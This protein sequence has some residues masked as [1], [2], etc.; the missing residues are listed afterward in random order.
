[1]IDLYTW[2]T[3]NGFKVSIMLEEIALPYAVIPV[4]IRNGDQFDPRYLRL[5]PNNKIPTI[6]DR[7]GPGGVPY[8]VFESGA[9]LIYLAEKT[10][11]LMPADPAGRHRVLQ[12]LMFQVGGIGPMLGQAHHFRRYAPEPIAYAIERYTREAERLYRVMDRRLGEAEYLAGAYSIADI[13]CF[14]WIR[15]HRWQGQ[16]LDAFPN[17]KRW[18]DAV[19]ARPAVGRGLRVPA[20]AGAIAATMDD[21]TRSI[22]FGDVQHAKR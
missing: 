1:M 7:D 11:C 18:F 8:T 5:N 19:D 10:G 2:P 22:L 12:W 3:P 4:D 16:D 20:E 9:I 21:A 14:P 6:V 13:A 15:P 17:L